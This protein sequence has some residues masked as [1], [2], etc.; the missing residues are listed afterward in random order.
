[1]AFLFQWHRA[2][3]TC[4]ESLGPG[5]PSDYGTRTPL[6]DLDGFIKRVFF[7]FKSYTV[8]RQKRNNPTLKRS[9]TISGV[10]EPCLNRIG[11]KGIGLAQYTDDTQL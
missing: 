2:A 6:I 1:M 8:A 9:F 3:E 5:S 11:F 4:Q 7:F 10:L